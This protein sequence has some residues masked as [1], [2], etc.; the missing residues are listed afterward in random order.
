MQKKKTETYTK[1]NNYSIYI[2]LHPLTKECYIHFCT[3]TALQ[4]TYKNHYILKNSLT[5]KLFQEHKYTLYPPEMYLLENIQCTKSEAYVHQIIWLKYFT[6]NKY[7]PLN[8]PDDITA[9]QNLFE[10]N[11]E[12]YQKISEIPLE[13]I[14]NNDARLF[15]NY[16]RK[17]TKT[18]DPIKRD[19]HFLVSEEERDIIKNNAK[20]NNLTLSAYMREVALTGN[21]ININYDAIKE[22]TREISLIKTQMNAVIQMLVDTN[23]AF[24]IDIENMIDLLKEIRDSEKTLLK[25]VRKEQLSLMKKITKE[26]QK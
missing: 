24:P 25:S 13:N 10:E 6:N 3:M 8:H 1:K 5:K 14:I 4:N 19:L 11:R 18:D 9:S 12:I 23:Q 16:G 22:H 21:T 2:I 17:K 20:K 7:L 15:G 26:L